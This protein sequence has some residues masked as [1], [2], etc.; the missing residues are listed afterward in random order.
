M[1]RSGNEDTGLGRQNCVRVWTLRE[2]RVLASVWF[3]EQLS[4]STSETLRTDFEIVYSETRKS[5]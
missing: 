3:G 5:T 4:L 1:W 2:F